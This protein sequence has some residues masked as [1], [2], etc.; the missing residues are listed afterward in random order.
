MI[1]LYLSNKMTGQLESKGSLV[2][3]IQTLKRSGF[4]LGGPSCSN[5]NMLHLQCVAFLL[6]E[7]HRK[8]SLQAN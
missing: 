3:R 6:Q 5:T 2:N 7:D 8:D 1:G 4:T